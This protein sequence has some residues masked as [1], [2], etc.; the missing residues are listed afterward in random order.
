M[1][2]A[3]RIWLTIAWGSMI[4]TPLALAQTTTQ[5]IT[6][7]S[8][9]E[10]P[11]WMVTLGAE[12]ADRPLVWVD[13][14]GNGTREPEEAWSDENAIPESE[15]CSF[16][17]PRMGN[18]L[19]I[20]GPAHTLFC[21]NSGIVKADLKGN[22]GLIKLALHY[23]KLRAIDL[24]GNM[25]L[26]AI[27]LNEN[28]LKEIN[29][30]GMNKLKEL[31]IASNRRIS[32]LDLKGITG[33]TKLDVGGT[34]LSSLPEG[35]LSKLEAL[36]ISGNRD[37]DLDLSRV[38]ALNEF[39]AGE[40][41]LSK[42]DLS[43]L[44]NLTTLWAPNNILEDVNLSNNPELDQIM[45]KFNNIKSI[46]LSKNPKLR[47]LY[48]ERNDIQ[49]LKLST[50]NSQLQVLDCVGSTALTQI[51]VSKHPNLFA[52]Q[53]DETGISTLD[54][55]NN[56]ALKELTISD[57]PIKELDLSKNPNLLKLGVTR[58]KIEE[59]DLSKNTSLQVLYCANNKLKKLDLQHC[60]QLEDFRGGEN[61]LE[62]IIFNSTQLHTVF[63][64]SNNIKKEAMGKIV[65]SLLK[66]T[67]GKFM[68]VDL[69]VGKEENRCT[70]AQVDQLKSKGWKVLDANTRGDKPLPYAGFDDSSILDVAVNAVHIYPTVAST[71]FTIS[72]ASGK[73]YTI[74]TL[75]GDVAAQGILSEEVATLSVASLPVGNYIIKVSGTNEVHR[76]QI[77]R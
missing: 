72:G 57:T 62:E 53:L 12:E 11:L 1:K 26:E 44:P 22:P 65:A 21:G 55:S 43:A 40:C 73:S 48:L 67:P 46:D 17:G 6:L 10:M 38:P 77:A 56:P 42:L 66:S 61:Q 69:S 7:E 60:T 71:S 37:F 32:K 76:L 14:N 41:N 3:L 59:L 23:N 27:N 70:I 63:C 16:T 24:S 34:S 18:T 20:Y 64:Y 33:L 8:E 2:K 36:N 58:C 28:Q 49:N 15:L 51:D 68:V 47:K 30:S 45:L 9:E 5:K 75:L 52:L 13:L 31:R 29:L 54:V 4:A 74:Y 39:A 19:S 50:E 35:D 25:L